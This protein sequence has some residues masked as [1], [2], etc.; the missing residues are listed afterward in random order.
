MVFCFDDSCKD[1]ILRDGV[2]PNSTYS[3]NTDTMVEV[4]G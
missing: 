1:Q 2:F 3:V 4:S